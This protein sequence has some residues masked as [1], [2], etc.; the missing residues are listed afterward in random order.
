MNNKDLP[1][2]FMEILNNV[3]AKRARFVIDTILR[4]GYCSTEDLKKGG[5]EH[6]PRAARDVREL[7]IPLVTE[8]MKD[9]AG[10]TIAVYKFGDW[11]KAKKKNL[12]AKTSGRSQL[13]NKLKDA[14]VERY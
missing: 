5:Y 6:A 9:S 4:Q 7:G 12:L 13:S 10:K 8:K 3:T 1:K 14:L 2:D 11:E